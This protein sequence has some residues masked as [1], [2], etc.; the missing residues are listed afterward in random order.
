VIDVQGYFYPAAG[1]CPD[2]MVAAGSICVDK[3]EA[4]VWNAATGGS[5][6]AAST[7][8]AD[9]SDCGKN[10]ANPIYAR[11]VE[12]VTPA[13]QISWYQ[14]A[15]ACANAGKRLPTTAEWQ[16]AASGTP[17]GNADCNTAGGAVGTTGALTTCVSSA[18]AFDM[19]GNLWEWAAELTDFPTAGGFQFSVTDDGWGRI[20]GASYN[21][22]N[23]DSTQ[24]IATVG[25]GPGLANNGE[26]GFRC[27]R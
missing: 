21:S 27:V 20:L 15:Q 24:D 9:G 13:S 7:C 26:I 22:G 2:D 6:I 19:V 23:S 3:Y 17:S 12:G 18:G 4:S 5:Q 8:L 16:M 10:A 25:A 14:A 1:T 11:S